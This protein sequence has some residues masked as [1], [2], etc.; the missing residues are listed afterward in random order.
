MDYYEE[1]IREAFD[2]SGIIATE[3]QI[4]NVVGWVKNAAE[5]EYQAHG[6]ECI[7]NPMESEI[8]R[9]RAAHAEEIARLKNEI[10][11]YTNSIA[12][13]YRV[14]GSKVYTENGSVYISNR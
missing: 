4:E 3:E 14:D 11:A 13:D 9:I 7:P 2:D 6:Y 8:D 10:D 12:R 5:N 1:T